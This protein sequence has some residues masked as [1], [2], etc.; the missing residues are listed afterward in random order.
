MYISNLAFL[1]LRENK[2][3]KI[4]FSLNSDGSAVLEHLPHPSEVEGLSPPARHRE[5]ENG[6][7]NVFF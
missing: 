1:S 3:F 2:T 5:R 7:K 4:V 6:G